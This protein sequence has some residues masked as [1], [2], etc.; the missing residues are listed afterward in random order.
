MKRNSIPSDKSVPVILLKDSAG[1]VIG[2][3]AS[4]SKQ[5]VDGFE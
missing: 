3:A 4:T 1:A 2:Y 5:Y